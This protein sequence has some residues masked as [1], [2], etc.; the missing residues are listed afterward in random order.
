ML[1]SSHR[2]KAVSVTHGQCSSTD[3]QLCLQ[4]CGC[5]CIE[6]C[7]YSPGD[8]EALEPTCY[9]KEEL[10]IKN[11]PNPRQCGLNDKC[12]KYNT[13]NCGLRYS[14]PRQAFYCGVPHP[15]AWPPVVQVCCM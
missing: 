11:V 10:D 5:E 8:N 13:S 4:Q 7:F 2:L 14:K 9:T 15:V 6:C 12:L 1:E 3:T